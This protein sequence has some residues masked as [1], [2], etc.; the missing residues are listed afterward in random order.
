MPVN[1]TSNAIPI[2]LILFGGMNSKPLLQVLDIKL[3]GSS[4]ECYRL[5]LS[6]FVSTQQAILATP[7][8]DQLETGTVLK[9]SVVQLIENICSTIQN[10]NFVHF[11]SLSLSQHA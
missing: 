10:R 8:N 5:L 9:G 2:P 6:D 3:I 1:L 4:Q 7:L 11:F